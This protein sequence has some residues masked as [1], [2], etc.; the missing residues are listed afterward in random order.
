MVFE[1]K[2]LALLFGISVLFVPI[3]ANADTSC[4][5]GNQSVGVIRSKDFSTTKEKV[6]LDLFRSNEWKKVSI[7]KFGLKIC[8]GDKIKRPPNESK[9]ALERENSRQELIWNSEEMVFLPTSMG[10]VV[11]EKVGN[12]IDDFFSRQKMGKHKTF[13]TQG[14]SDKPWTP[15]SGIK[16]RE[17][18]VM[19][20]NFDLSLP[21]VASCMAKV[22]L[23]NSKSG[24]TQIGNLV[25]DCG[26]KDY[27]VFEFKKASFKTG[28]FWEISVDE[29]ENKYIIGGFGVSENKSHLG[30]M[31]ESALNS[32]E[33]E[34]T[35]AVCG[36]FEDVK[37]NS[38]STFNILRALSEKKSLSIRFLD[39]ANLEHLII[40]PSSVADPCAR[41]R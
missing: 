7:G 41:I 2:Q 38:L 9:L 19:A 14:E 18:V 8:E 1:M 37:R 25:G 35:N 12:W 36:Y 26:E 29:F 28:E 20:G 27:Y 24:F 6:E 23:K 31:I 11:I 30:Y 40:F 10:Q 22:I 15:I 34:I 17:A 32:E 33:I 21:I 13:A 3:G 4:G 5:K 39:G 16:S